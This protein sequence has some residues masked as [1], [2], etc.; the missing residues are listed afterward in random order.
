MKFFTM[1]IDI[2]NG[3]AEVKSNAHWGEYNPLLKA[4]V[5][6]DLIYDL[7]KLYNRVLEEMKGD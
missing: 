5:L 6:N 3:E 1:K 4:D 7:T 2:Q